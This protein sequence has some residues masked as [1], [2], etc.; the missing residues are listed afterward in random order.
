MNNFVFPINYKK[1]AINPNLI[2][3]ED[4]FDAIVIIEN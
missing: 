2:G 3:F 4:H 1:M